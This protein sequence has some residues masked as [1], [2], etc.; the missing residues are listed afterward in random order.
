[1]VLVVSYGKEEMLMVLL[2]ECAAVVLPDLMEVPVEPKLN[3][4]CLRLQY[5]QCPFLD[6]LP[7]LLLELSTCQPE[8]AEVVEHLDRNLVLKKLLDEKL[9]LL[10][11]VVLEVL[12]DLDCDWSW[13]LTAVLEPWVPEVR[14]VEEFPGLEEQV[15]TAASEEPVVLVASSH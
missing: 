6:C 15:A 1:M 10:K 8:V 14:K 7:Q 12:E 11:S 5:R 4:S 2:V 13:L 9:E 3:P